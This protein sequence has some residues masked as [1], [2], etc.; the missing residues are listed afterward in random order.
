VISGLRS[1]FLPAITKSPGCSLG[2]DQRPHVPVY[3]PT[4]AMFSFHKGEMLPRSRQSSVDS[5][6]F[7]PH[8]LPSACEPE[9]PLDADDSNAAAHPPTHHPAYS[10]RRSSVFKM[11][12]R[13][14][15]ATST[16]PSLLSISRSELHEHEGRWHGPAHVPQPGN[17]IHSETSKAGTRRSFFRG[18]KGKRNSDVAM[19]IMPDGVE[20]DPR[21]KR[22][23]VLRKDRKPSNDAHESTVP[24]IHQ[25]SKPLDF[26]HLSHADRHQVAALEKAT[27]EDITSPIFPTVRPSRSH[28]RGF[29]GEK[30]DHLR[31]RDLSPR[32]TTGLDP[33]SMTPLGERLH[34]RSQEAPHEWHQ[35]E[36]VPPVAAGFPNLRM[37]RSVESFSQPGVSPRK[38]SEPLNLVSQPA[39]SMWHPP[40]AWGEVDSWPHEEAKI[41]RRS[42]RSKRESGVWDSFVLPGVSSPDQVLGNPEDSYF[43]HALTTPDDSAIHAVTPPFSPSLADVAEEPERFTSPRSPP[44]PP[45]RTP[46]T[47]KSPFFES[48][49]FADHRSPPTTYRSHSHTLS[50]PRGRAPGSRRSSIR[51]SSQVSETLGS[52][53]VA[54]RTPRPNVPNRRN[55]NTWRAIEASWEDDVDYIYENALEADCDSAW[56][57]L[58]DDNIHY[59]S[60]KETNHTNKNQQDNRHTPYATAPDDTSAEP[61]ACEMFSGTFRTSLLVPSTNSLPDLAPA[62]A[63]SAST[64]STG[65]T[66]PSDSFNTNR[67]SLDEG[68]VLT[69]S[70][71]IPQEYKEIREA[72]YEDLLDEYDGS[73]RHFP[74]IDASQSVN[75]STRSSRV[76]FSRRSSYDSSMMSIQGSGLWSYPARRSASSAGSVPDLVPSR[77]TRKDQGFSLVMDNLSEQVASLAHFE[78]GSVEDGMTPPGRALDGQTFFTADDETQ[79]TD[80]T[81]ILV[82]SELRES[83]ELARRGSQPK[84]SVGTEAEPRASQKVIGEGP[85]RSDRS[86]MRQHKLTLSDSA[87][88]LL[89]G[90]SI[91]VPNAKGVSRTRAATT[92]HTQQP[93]LSLFPSPPRQPIQS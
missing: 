4:P 77:R 56:D 81:R 3:A 69:P 54:R 60:Q 12:S 87:A 80:R 17:P 57:H 5:Q 50:S 53:G 14:N 10:A 13:S 75:G 29:N 85:Q 15:T 88:K 40:P 24:L 68:F 47:P 30:E 82:A 48:F 52:Y 21:Q 93:I 61:V 42:S 43:G 46:S 45:G 76:R 92:A 11:R 8:V 38:H 2:S 26:Q 59:D 90:P 23:S 33:Q 27:V 91:T 19:P 16:T 1:G 32:D 28:S 51:T 9:A 65:L 84:T 44:P 71:L 74:M 83:L 73:D 18:R 34:P 64:T 67:S 25:I 49:S 89:S 35:S 6:A 62:S 63:I 55:S 70:L 36:P 72:T 41:A 22:S 37:A 31:F 7:L 86:P 20:T 66:T 58:D 78:Q 79:E 39:P